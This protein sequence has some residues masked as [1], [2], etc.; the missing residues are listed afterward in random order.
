MVLDPSPPPLPRIDAHCLTAGFQ[1]IVVLIVQYKYTEDQM[2]KDLI[3]R[4]RLCGTSLITQPGWLLHF[5]LTKMVGR[6]CFVPVMCQLTN[7]TF[8]GL[9]LKHLRFDA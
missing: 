1:E 2:L 9:A 5:R 3:F 6:K 4:T 8:A 7:G